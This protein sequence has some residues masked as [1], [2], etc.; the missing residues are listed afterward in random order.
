MAELTD[1]EL[2]KITRREVEKYAGFSDNATAYPISD[3]K[4]KI[5]AVTAI[6]HEP[7]ED[8]SWIIVQAHVLH[9]HVIVDEDN[10]LDKKLIDAL[11]QAGIPRNQIILAYAAEN[12]LV[13]LKQDVFE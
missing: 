2:V 13:P 4:R 12:N 7:G 6:R 3:D 11:T 1:G 5:Y 10:V 8:H 9:Q